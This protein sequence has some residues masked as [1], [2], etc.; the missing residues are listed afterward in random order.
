MKRSPQ[1]DP[2]VEPTTGKALGQAG[3]APVCVVNTFDR[4][5]AVLLNTPV[6]SEWA[7]G[8]WSNPCCTVRA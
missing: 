4:G 7:P 6:K 8:G 1:I 5:R 3:D 2:A